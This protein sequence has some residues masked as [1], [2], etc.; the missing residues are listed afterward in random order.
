MRL[1]IP[2][3]TKQGYIEVPPRGI[4]DYS[5]PTSKYR[6]GRVQGGGKICPTIMWGQSEI[7]FYEGVYD[8]GNPH[9]E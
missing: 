2:Q 8:C 4:F 6:R 9:K 7:L 1:R 5:Y 3:P